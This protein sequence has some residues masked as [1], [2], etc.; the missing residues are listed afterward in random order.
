LEKTNKILPFDLTPSLLSKLKTILLISLS[1]I[2]IGIL[3]ANIAFGFVLYR[4]YKGAL[5]GFLITSISSTVE[6]F[7]FHPK[8]KR[9]SFTIE[10][11]ARTIFYILLISFSTIFVVVIHESLDNN[12]SIITTINGTY[13][14]K[15]I[16]GDF[17]AIF[18]FAVVISLI[19][20]FLWQINR[21]LGKGILLNVMLG[22]YRRPKLEQRIFMF[23]DLKSSTT[24]G[25]SLGSFKYSSLLQDFF[26]D[27]T[28]PVIETKG[29]IYQYIGDE[30]VLTWK[31]NKKIPYEY[32]LICFFNIKDRINEK[33]NYY[34]EKYSVVPGF[35]AGAHLGEAIVTE[36]GDLKKEIVFH[37][38]TVNTTS[39]I[40]TE[41]GQQNMDLI[42]SSELLSKLSG[43]FMKNVNIEG[44]GKIKLRGKEKEIELFSIKKSDAACRKEHFIEK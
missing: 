5:I 1:G 9:L 6:I 14:R 38:D 21:M 30:V 40:R 43:E 22:K 26:S 23:L 39:R 33:A 18:I 20:N 15:F 25:E 31:V 7:V 29:E 37:G 44:M 17:I 35:K 41:A 36:V 28:D 2:L 11:L 10:L 42:I 12:T 27:I 8:F 32:F 24:L 3:Y 16:T 19:L 13:F 4:V 34:I